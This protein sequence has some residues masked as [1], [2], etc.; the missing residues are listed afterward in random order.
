MT[1]SSTLPLQQ[2]VDAGIHHDS[3]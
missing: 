1:V 2:V 3:S